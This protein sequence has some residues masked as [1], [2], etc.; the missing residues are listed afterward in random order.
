MFDRGKAKYFHGREHEKKIFH[1]AK[2][3]KS[4]TTFLIQGSPVVGKTALLE[5][6]K[7]IAIDEN[8]GVVKIKP[9]GLWDAGQLKKY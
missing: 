6:L 2:K 9:N 8:W 4:G 1:K 7:Q 3:T 5:E